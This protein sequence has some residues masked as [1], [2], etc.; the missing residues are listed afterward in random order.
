MLL[1]FSIV[2]W[3]CARAC[4]SRRRSPVAAQR[5]RRRLST[6]ASKRQL[7]ATSQLPQGG[8]SAQH[9]ALG[10]GEAGN[11]CFRC[12][13]YAARRGVAPGAGADVSDFLLAAPARAGPD[14][15]CDCTVAFIVGRIMRSDSST[16]TWS[17]DQRKIAAV[18]KVVG[19]GKSDRGRPAY[20]VRIAGEDL[21]P[22]FRS[23]FHLVSFSEPTTLA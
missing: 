3:R 23:C 1:S 11:A 12:R 7:R 4:R 20:A 14:R 18:W 16:A 13:V 8:T 19:H 22:V 6:D 5:L 15:A 10:V 17:D 2:H 9:V 21:H